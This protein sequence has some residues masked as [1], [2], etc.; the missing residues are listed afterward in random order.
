MKILNTVWH[1]SMVRGATPVFGLTE[2]FDTLQEVNR[3]LF[4]PAQNWAAVG[5]LRTTTGNEFV[6]RVQEEPTEYAFRLL[7]SLMISRDNR[8]IIQ[9][10]YRSSGQN[11]PE[12]KHHWVPSSGLWTTEAIRLRYG[13]D[14]GPEA[15]W[16]G[17]H[18]FSAPKQRWVRHDK[19]LSSVEDKLIMAAL[20]V[21]LGALK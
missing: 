1:P 13:D 15:G 10:L 14:A 21:F 12:V 8:A 9:P 11:N 4:D 5:A 20:R 7:T 17:K 6:V 18:Y 16:I 3:R 19:T 2:E